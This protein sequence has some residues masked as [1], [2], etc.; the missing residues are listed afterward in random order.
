MDCGM[1]VHA[2]CVYELGLLGLILGVLRQSE[3]DVFELTFH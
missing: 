1:I 3:Q 2:L